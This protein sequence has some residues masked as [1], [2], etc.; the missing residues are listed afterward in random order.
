MTLHDFC[1][2]SSIF[3]AINESNDFLQPKP[4]FTK[5]EKSAIDEFK[6]RFG[7]ASEPTVNEQMK[8]KEMVNEV[9]KKAKNEEKELIKGQCIK[10][11]HCRMVVMVGFCGCCCFDCYY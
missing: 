7:G 10:M 5:M 3:T 9:K 2:H 11:I 1:H 4:L 6:K 8:R